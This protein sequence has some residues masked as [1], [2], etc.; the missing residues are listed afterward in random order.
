MP[1]E[2]MDSEMCMID[3]LLS[4]L[5][6]LFTPQFCNQFKGSGAVNHL[7]GQ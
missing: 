5:F 1:T 6:R 7:T 3:Q 4:I 2:T